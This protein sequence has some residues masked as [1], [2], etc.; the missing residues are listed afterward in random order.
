MAVMALR[1]NFVGSKRQAREL[2]EQGAVRLNGEHARLSSLGDSFALFD[3]YW[4]V[5]KGK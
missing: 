5:Q 1:G 2:F 3:T 4:I